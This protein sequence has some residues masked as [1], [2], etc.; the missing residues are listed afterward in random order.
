MGGLAKNWG[1]SLPG[2]GLEPPLQSA[3]VSRTKQMSPQQPFKLLSET[4]TLHAVDELYVC[5]I[6]TPILSVNLPIC[7]F[8]CVCVAFHCMYICM[9]V[10]SARC[11]IYISRLCY[12][13]SV[14][15]CLSVCL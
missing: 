2:P 1:A 8:F 4:I 14:R 6:K 13:A 10:F 9:H 5:V 15:V 12:D 11:N 7:R 3:A